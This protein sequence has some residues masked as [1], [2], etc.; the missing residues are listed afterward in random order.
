VER[1]DSRGK[2]GYNGPSLTTLMSLGPCSLTMSM[3]KEKE[4]GEENYA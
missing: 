4:M 1:E 2:Q 3:R